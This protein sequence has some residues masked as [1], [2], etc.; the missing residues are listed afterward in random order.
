MHA[1]EKMRQTTVVNTLECEDFII[2]V[3]KSIGYKFELWAAR[4]VNVTKWSTAQSVFTVVLD[5]YSSLSRPVL[6]EIHDVRCRTL[7]LRYEDEG[8][9]W[10]LEQWLSVLFFTSFWSRPLA[11]FEGS[12]RSCASS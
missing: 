4:G 9:Q 6:R 7:D 10:Q 1:I 11:S 2:L 3:L 5:A 12:W 8:E